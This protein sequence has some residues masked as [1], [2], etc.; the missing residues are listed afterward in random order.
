ERLSS[1][2]P[3]P[4]GG[5]VAA[6]DAAMASALLAMVSQLTLNRKR[7][8]AVHEQVRELHDQAVHLRNRAGDLAE[9]DA[10]AY[11]AVSAA[12]VLPRD[13]DE[14]R[15]CRKDR[16]QSALKAAAEPPLATMEVAAEALNLAAVLVNIGNTSAISDVGTAALCARSA[17]HAARLNVQINMAGVTDDAWREEMIIR[18]QAI[19]KPDP[20]EQDVLARV[21]SIIQGDTV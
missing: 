1:A 14:Q 20:V 3:V 19:P 9:A 18:L 16:M 21:V 4:G 5:S 17:Y 2:D 12:L 15:S 6:I 13:N 11:A 8:A 10:A 7:Y